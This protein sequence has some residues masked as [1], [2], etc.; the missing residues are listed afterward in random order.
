M[1]RLRELEAAK[2]RPK[3]LLAESALWIDATRGVLWKMIV[4]SARRQ[5]SYALA[6]QVSPIA[7]ACVAAGISC[8]ASSYE[9]RRSGRV[10]LIERTKE[11]RQK[12]PVGV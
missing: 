10:D 3:P 12:K 6:R 11:V 1:K 4:V 2:A 5:L 7:R 9:S 8:S